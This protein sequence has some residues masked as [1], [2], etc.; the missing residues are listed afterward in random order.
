MNCSS[1]HLSKEILPQSIAFGCVLDPF[2][3]FWAVVNLMSSG[4]S[5]SVVP[6]HMVCRMGHEAPTVGT[7]AV[8]RNSWPL[9]LYYAKSLLSDDA[10]R[11]YGLIRPRGLSKQGYPSSLKKRANRCGLVLG[12]GLN[13][14]SQEKYPETWTG[15]L[16]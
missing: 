12:H 11:L 10:G 1:E 9:G 5:S 8:G 2:V 6:R 15:G 13:Q 3:I 4:G 7:K 14:E 16:I